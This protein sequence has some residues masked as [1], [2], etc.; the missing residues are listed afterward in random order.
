MPLSAW[1]PQ[2]I[3]FVGVS[4]AVKAV[5][6]LIT[7]GFCNTSFTHLGL[8]KKIPEL[9]FSSRLPNSLTMGI[10]FFDN[11]VVKSLG[12]VSS[13]SGV[14]HVPNP[15]Q[16]LVHVHGSLFG[17]RTVSYTPYTKGSYQ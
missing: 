3:R 4:L 9:R 1:T 15:E 6:V 11:R 12:V 13:A 7:G 8:T 2:G 14:T 17:I 16:Y 5:R 10:V